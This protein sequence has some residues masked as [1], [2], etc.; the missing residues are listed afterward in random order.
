VR[1][2]LAGFI[3]LLACWRINHW[4]KRVCFWDDDL[5]EELADIRRLMLPMSVKKH[6]QRKPK[7]IETSRKPPNQ[8]HTGIKRKDL[9]SLPPLGWL[10]RL[11]EVV[12]TAPRG[13]LPQ[14]HAVI[15]LRP[16]GGF[17]VVLCCQ[18]SDVMMYRK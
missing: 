1:H 17:N 15:H 6:P 12:R 2:G 10:R 4:A 3:C 7:K 18:R 5:D 16:L 9:P 14:T 13:R 11:V 8:A